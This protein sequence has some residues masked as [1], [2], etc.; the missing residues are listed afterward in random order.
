[1]VFDWNI[2]REIQ[3]THFQAGIIDLENITDTSIWAA[4]MEIAVKHKI[5]HYLN[6]YNYTTESI[7]PNAWVFKDYVNIQD[8]YKTFSGKPLKGFPYIN[9]P[10][11]RLL[12]H[13]YNI[14]PIKLLNLLPYEKNKA[15]STIKE[16]FDWKDYGNKHSESVF[17]RF[18]QGYILPNKFGIDKRKAHYSNLI[19][20]NQITREEALRLLEKPPYTP[21]E[22][23]QDMDF[24]L[25]KMNFT[26]EYLNDYIARPGRPH[27]DFKSAKFNPS[28]IRRA[29]NFM[30]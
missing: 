11:K 24:F 23:A 18:F 28:F 26:K 25:S 8:I 7:L 22:L 10:W 12:A 6:G 2:Y 17:T 9:S 13:W 29:L 30:K 4:L 19:C 16:Y 27:Q 15:V 21:E 5:K 20:S 3:E 1:V 14:Q